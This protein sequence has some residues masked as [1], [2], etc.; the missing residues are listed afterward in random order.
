MRRARA[1]LVSRPGPVRLRPPRAR[2]LLRNLVVREGRGGPVRSRCAWSPRRPAPASPGWRPRRW[3]E[4]S[5]ATGCVD[6]DREHGRDDGGRGARALLSGAEQLEEQLGE[7]APAHLAAGLLPDQH[8]DGRA[9]LRAGRRVRA[10][11]RLRAPVRPLLG[12][13]TVGLT[14]APAPPS[15]GGWRSWSRRWPTRSPTRSST[16]S[17]TRS[18]FAGD[19]RLALREL[20]ERAGRPDVLVV[21]PPRAGLSQKAV[22][23]IIEAGTAADRLRVLQPHDAGAQRRAARRGGLEAGPRAAGG[24]VPPDPAHRVRRAAGARRRGR[25]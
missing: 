5:T 2:G 11:A 12:I 14:L 20:V 22:R 8:R 18:F 15:C 23:R 19:V 1:R 3:P 25:R 4:R 16:R 7:P 24:H 21:D 17:T 6:A 10:A 9:A 13:G